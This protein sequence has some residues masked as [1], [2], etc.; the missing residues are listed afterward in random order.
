MSATSLHARDLARL[1]LLAMALAACPGRIEN[2]ED[3]VG[4]GA[5]DSGAQACL[6]GVNN[7]EAQLIR[8]R[9][10][11]AGCHDRGMRAGGL[12]LASDNV[13]SRLVG[14]RSSG[15]MGAVL[16]DP[17]APSAGYFMAKLG[18]SP[19]CGSRMPLGTPA[20]S[21]SELACVRGWL[22][23]LRGDAG[24]DASPDGA[25][26]ATVD[27][28]DVRDVSDVSDVPDATDVADAAID[29]T[30]DA[31]DAADASEDSDVSDGAVERDAAD[32]SDASDAADGSDAADASVDVRDAGDASVDVRDAG[33]ASV[34]VRDA[35]DAGDASDVSDASDAG[36]A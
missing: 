25:V 12:D 6:L 29:A 4:N 30:R 10:A 21:A 33:D 23:T 8:P 3:F 9:C 17:N 31:S 34:D 26:D 28:A 19:T 13:A 20:L 24:L 5:T 22:G 35:G 15:C 27:V 32:A 16:V 2:P 1:T 36:D 7:V 11:T 18:A 14:V